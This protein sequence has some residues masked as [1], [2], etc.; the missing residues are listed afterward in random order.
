MSREIEARTLIVDPVNH[1]QKCLHEAQQQEPLSKNFD[2]SA[3]MLIYKRYVSIRLKS[4]KAKAV[5]IFQKP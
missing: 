5:C 4:R 1:G 3:Y 2:N